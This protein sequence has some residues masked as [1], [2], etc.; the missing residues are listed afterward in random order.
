MSIMENAVVQFVEALR[1]FDSFRVHYG[2]GVLLTSNIA[3][4][5][6]NVVFPK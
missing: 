3:I 6:G 1:G 4:K 5:N 2:P